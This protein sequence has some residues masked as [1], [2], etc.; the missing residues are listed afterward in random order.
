MSN[1]N[2]NNTSR[3]NI[4]K[5]T[6]D[7]GT[8]NYNS[9]STVTSS[10]VMSNLNCLPTAT[11]A[12]VMSPVIMSTSTPSTICTPVA[13]GPPPPIKRPF[14]SHHQS[15]NV[16]QTFD[17]PISSNGIHQF[18]RPVPP[19]PVSQG[20]SNISPSHSVNCSR[21]GST[22]IPKLSSIDPQPSP[23]KKVDLANIFPTSIDDP[24][25]A[26]WTNVVTKSLSHSENVSSSPSVSYKMH[27]NETMNK[28]KLFNGGSSSNKFS[29]VETT[30]MTAE[31]CEP[32]NF[33][34]PITCDNNS[35]ASSSSVGTNNTILST[36]PFTAPVKL[37][38]ESF[39]LR[40]E[41]QIEM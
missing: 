25:D 40:K 17:S 28:A 12:P 5:D 8:G 24:F 15:R 7:F 30:S 2:V 4:T 16:N 37:Q 21:N 3:R 19:P 23:V 34:P 33:I 11:V 41:F 9:S 36:N 31:S 29:S 14:A 27:I 6:L 32:T 38:T 39:G 18:R 22:S 35:L 10:N 26:E 13:T 20:S 1:V